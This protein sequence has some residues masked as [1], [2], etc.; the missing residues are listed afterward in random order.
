VGGIDL[1][2]VDAMFQG[3]AMQFVCIGNLDRQGVALATV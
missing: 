2:Q 1:A 3:R